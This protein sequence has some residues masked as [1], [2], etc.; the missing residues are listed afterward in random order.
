MLRNNIRRGRAKDTNGR[1]PARTQRPP[2][3]ELKASAKV[4]SPGCFLLQYKTD[5]A[6]DVTVWLKRFSVVANRA[7]PTIG[8]IVDELA[9]RLPEEVVRPDF[10]AI[11]DE[12][13]RYIAR[14][15][16][17]KKIEKNLQI[18]AD[19]EKEKPILFALTE[20]NISERSEVEVRKCMDFN[21]YSAAKDPLP[22]IISLLQLV[23]LW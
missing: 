10:A 7:C 11:E 19:I 6:N 22:F 23:I 18:L 1:G 20:M 17:L 14:Q 15:V 16:Y 12:D 3:E 21:T 13:D 5:G 9:Y 2:R 8:R 4:A